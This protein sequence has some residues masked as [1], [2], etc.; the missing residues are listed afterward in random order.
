MPFGPRG[1]IS[2]SSPNKS[3]IEFDRIPAAFAAASVDVVGPSSGNI[4]AIF[5]CE[6]EGFSPLFKAVNLANRYDLFVISSKGQSVTAARQ[7]SGCFA[8]LR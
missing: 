5:F 1:T 4:S 6:K 8:A 3:A 7:L 2:D